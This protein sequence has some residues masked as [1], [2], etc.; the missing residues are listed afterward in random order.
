MEQVIARET[1]PIRLETDFKA[2]RGRIRLQAMDAWSRGD[3]RALVRLAFLE[4]AINTALA[5]EARPQ[6]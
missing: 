2:I 4:R 6:V 1:T 3:K 5:L